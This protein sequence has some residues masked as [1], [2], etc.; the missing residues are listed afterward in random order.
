MPKIIVMYPYPS[1]AE[2]FDRD[3]TEDHAP[4][5]TTDTFPKITK[6]VANKIVG[7][8][9][10]T[11]PKYRLI[12]ELHFASM[13]DLQAAAAS[14]SAQKAV[15]HAFEISSGGPPVVIVAEEEVKNF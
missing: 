8:P 3:Y 13:E 14:D 4:M 1:D 5:V 9:D 6:F 11:Q 10:G 12:A 15:A 7:T 2:K